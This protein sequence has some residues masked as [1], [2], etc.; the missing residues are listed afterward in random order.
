M[1]RGGEDVERQS[2]SKSSE[3]GEN[4]VEINQ[5]SEALVMLLGDASRIQEMQRALELRMG[6]V[7]WGLW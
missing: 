6:E 3:N 2:S 1:D 5:K 4:E 7:R